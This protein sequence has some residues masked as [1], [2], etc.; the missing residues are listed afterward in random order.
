MKSPNAAGLYSRVV[1]DLMDSFRA[2]ASDDCRG[3]RDCLAGFVTAGMLQRMKALNILPPVDDPAEEE[4]RLVD[5]LVADA[6]K[7]LEEIEG[8]AD[9]V[10]RRQAS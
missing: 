5:R 1:D 10:A 8:R 6:L 7:R 9:G 4:R 3:D 2:H